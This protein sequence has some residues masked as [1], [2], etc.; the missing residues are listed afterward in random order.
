MI[1]P[2][3]W[4]NGGRGLEQF[5]KKML[6]DKSIKYIYDF[7]DGH[8]CFQNV[9]IAGG[10]CYFLWDSSYNGLCNFVSCHNGK[11]MSSPRDLSSTETLIR[12]QEEVSILSKI[13]AQTTSFLSCVAY[14]QKP[15][16]L[17]TYIKP[18][19]DGDIFLRYNGGIGKYSKELVPINKDLID[20]WKLIISC[21]TA[22]HAG[23]SDKNGQK[24]IFSTMEIL[25]PKTICTET[26][27]LLN[28]FDN[29]IECQNMLKYMKS[30][31]VR[32][33]V[34]AVT[35][36]QHM[37]K[38][39]F[40]FVPLQDFTSKSDIDWTKSVAE[41]DRQLY[42]KYNLTDEEIAFIEQMIKPME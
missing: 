19:E 2:A 7:I 38:S 26:Y 16:G 18:L 10:V 28:T 11:R 24:R 41:I 15:F 5:R 12:H 17:R 23:E 31:F 37:S 36:T 22:E 8:D 39:N 13:T 30:K 6:N 14:S 21:L 40:Q 1:M 9:D 42:A 4:Y 29:E 32:A 34:A 20:K 25:S 3:K 27:M 33:L 35:S